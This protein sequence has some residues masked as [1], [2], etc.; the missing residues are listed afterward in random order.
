[1]GSIINDA[2][3]P[4]VNSQSP[5]KRGIRLKGAKIKEYKNVQGV[6]ESEFERNDERSRKESVWT[7]SRDMLHKPI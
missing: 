4:E 5:M 3:N 7:L 6:L 1:M 2:E